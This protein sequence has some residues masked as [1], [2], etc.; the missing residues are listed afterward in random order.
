MKLSTLINTIETARKSGLQVAINNLSDGYVDPVYF[1]VVENKYGDK[2]RNFHTS[3]LIG[4][5]DQYVY[6]PKREDIV[7]DIGAFLGGYTIPAGKLAKRVYAFEPVYFEELVSNVK[8]N[9]LSNVNSYPFALGGKEGTQSVSY[10]R[11]AEAHTY[12]FD[13]LLEIVKELPTFIKCNCEGG[14]WSL[15]PENFDTVNTLEIQFHYSK[16]FPD[17]PSLLE[18]IRD[19]YLCTESTKNISGVNGIYQVRNIHGVRK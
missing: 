17:N 19:N 4:V 12:T 9:D 15:N 10:F 7:F 18:W 14:E 5:L 8:A 6:L 13:G 1:P 2:F 16:E 11:E 3:D